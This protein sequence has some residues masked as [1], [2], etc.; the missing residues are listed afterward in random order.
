MYQPY[1]MKKAPFALQR[2]KTKLRTLESFPTKAAGNFFVDSCADSEKADSLTY[3][4][5]WGET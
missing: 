3:S 1:I 5:A 4:K 2:L